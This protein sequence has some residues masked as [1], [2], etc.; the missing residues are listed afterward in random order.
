[1]SENKPLK[2]FVQK[3]PIHGLGVFAAEDIKQGE[4]IE[5]AP[6]LKLP[7]EEQNPMLGDYRY[8]WKDENNF[9][10]YVIALG[11]GSLYNHSDQPNCNFTNNV[12]N[13]SIDFISTRNIKKGEEIF[14]YYGG[15][16]YW[17]SR[18]YVH[19]K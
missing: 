9:N 7:I 18:E 6:I 19:V 8:W 3:S 12:K 4:L 10:S 5:I 16:E 2:V 17:S 15:N 11:Y 13:N 14:V 1:M